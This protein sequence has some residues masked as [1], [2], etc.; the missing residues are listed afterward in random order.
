MITLKLLII[1]D[2]EDDALILVREI[3]TGGFTCSWNRIETENEL[4]A[5]IDGEW[6]IIIIDYAMPH[7]NA[8]E[9][10][11]IIKENQCDI[12]CIVVSGQVGEETAVSVMKAGAHDYIQK[13]NYSRLIPA[14]QRELKEY[15]ILKEKKH[16]EQ[17]LKDHEEQQKVKLEHLVEERTARLK[18]VNKELATEI[19]IRK[20]IEEELIKFRVAIDNSADNVFLL[21]YPSLKFYDVSDSTCRDLGYTRKEFQT[22][23]PQDINLAFSNHDL[24]Q[25]FD[26]IIDKKISR[27]IETVHRTK[28]GLTFPVEVLLQSVAF[29]ESHC[30]VAVARDIT[31]RRKAE[32]A[33]EQALD[34][35]KDLNKQKTRF[36]SIVSHDFRTPLT[37]IQAT[38]DLLETYGMKWPEEKVISHYGRVRKSIDYMTQLIEEVLII[39]RVDEGRVVFQP[40]P[41]DIVEFSS[42]LFE[43]IKVIANE[44]HVMKYIDETYQRKGYLDEKIMTHVLNNLMS[45]AIKYSPK[46]GVIELHVA[47][48]GRKAKFEIKDEGIG[49]PEEELERLF[50]PFHRCSN[51][52]GI[53]GT[54]LGLGIVKRFVDIHGGTININSEEGKGTTVT[55]EIPTEKSAPRPGLIEEKKNIH[56]VK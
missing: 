32:A 44:H 18:E 3:Q 12:P 17:L 27:A 48:D 20:K 2:S 46:G 4:M 6:D 54:G 24:K 23:T 8:L 10:L 55:V 33:V 15:Q 5:T 14:I 56:S 49:I 11:K 21:E 51:V 9:A 52:S 36:L 40:E 47:H 13:G 53:K 19:S 22:M 28:S 35:E 16:A 43:E 39:G 50:E 31:E 7:F 45:N 42:E 34:K 37:V 38:I 29:G 41:L 25:I 30:V 26:E 1:D